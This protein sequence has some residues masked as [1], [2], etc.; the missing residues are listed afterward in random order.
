MSKVPGLVD[1]AYPEPFNTCPPPVT[2]HKPGQLPHS[3]IQKFFDEVSPNYFCRV[4]MLSI[5]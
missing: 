1:K 3:Q 4:V 2:I 5:G